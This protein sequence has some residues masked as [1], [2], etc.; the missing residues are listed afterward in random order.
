[1]DT[2]DFSELQKGIAILDELITENPT[3]ILASVKLW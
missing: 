2:V 1:M 3:K